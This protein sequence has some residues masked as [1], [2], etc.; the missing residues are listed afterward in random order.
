M[1]IVVLVKQVPDTWGDRTLTSSGVLDRQASES[2]IDEID[3]RALEVALSYQDSNDAEIVALTMGPASA[4]DVLRKCLAMGADSAVHVVDDALAGSDLGWTSAAIAAAISKAG[5]DL[6]IAGN[7]ST[8]GRG[9]V[10]PAMVAEHLGVPHLTFL[11]SVEISPERI[12]GERDTENGTVSVHAALPAVISVTERSAEPRFPSFKGIMR[13]KKKPLDVLTI[14]DLDP[15]I[16]SGM[17]RSVVLTATQRPARS[18]GT[19]VV[20]EGNAGNQLAEF[21]AAEHLI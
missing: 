3:E 8:D 7:E 4:T 12:S 10:I 18:A 11:T 5:Y 16:L 1:K 14:A 19:K 20:D 13:A 17:G 15:D 6:V 2:V 21:L 9:G